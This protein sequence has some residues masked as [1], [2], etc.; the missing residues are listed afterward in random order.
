MFLRDVSL[1]ESS[2]KVSHL[3]KYESIVWQTPERLFVRLERAFEVAQDAVAINA[4]GKPCFPE[5]GLERH[6]PVRGLFHRGTAVVVQINSV[7]IELAA[8]DSEAGPCQG[9]LRIK[10]NRLAIKVSGP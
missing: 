3:L 2:L 6:R 9:E 5:L 1:P 8:R 4:L 10:A 7:E